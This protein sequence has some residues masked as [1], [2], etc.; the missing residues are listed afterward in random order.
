M[1]GLALC[2]RSEPR[3][4]SHAT[5]PASARRAD[6]IV[7]EAELVSLK[8]RQVWGV[9]DMRVEC[10]TTCPSTSNASLG[11]VMGCKP[12]QF[13]FAFGSLNRCSKNFH[14]AFRFG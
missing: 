6:Q 3:I 7:L 2:F 5:A 13:A 14:F 11:V 8:A 12:R 10:G 4:T 1:G 9:S